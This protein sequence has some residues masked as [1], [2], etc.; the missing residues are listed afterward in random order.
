MLKLLVSYFSMKFDF[1]NLTQKEECQY[2]N[3]LQILCLYL[4]QSVH[5]M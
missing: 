4:N 1:V 2:S 5:Y 3:G